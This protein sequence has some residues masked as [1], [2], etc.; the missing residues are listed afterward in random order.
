MKI[1]TS[2]QSEYLW[3]PPV[4]TSSQL[5]T[6]A[7]DYWTMKEGR[8]DFPVVVCDDEI[9]EEFFEYKRRPLSAQREDG[10]WDLQ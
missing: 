4:A 8:E 3:L 1:S 6:V 10:T 7:G 5:K 9:V 2:S